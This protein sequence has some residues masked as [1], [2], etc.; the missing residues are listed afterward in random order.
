LDLK[1]KSPLQKLPESVAILVWP[2][3]AAIGTGAK[4]AV[5]QSILLAP[6]PPPPNS[7]NTGPPEPDQSSDRG[8]RL[9]GHAARWKIPDS[10]ATAFAVR[11]AITLGSFADGHLSFI[12]WA[13][14]R[15]HGSELIGMVR[16]EP[17][18]PLLLCAVNG[19][20]ANRLY[21][22]CHPT[23]CNHLLSCDKLFQ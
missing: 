8:A 22:R 16:R 20:K 18:R 1:R 10:G 21:F 9:Y 13:R 7:P 3:E 23:V 12:G 6:A 14:H 5:E 2:A 19:S 11:I 17:T 15:D 4:E